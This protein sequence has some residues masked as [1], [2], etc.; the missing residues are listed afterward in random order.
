MIDFILLI[1]LAYLGWS[2][3]DKFAKLT[4]RIY[5]LGRQE[6]GGCEMSQLLKELEGEQCKF[7]FD[8]IVNY[9]YLYSVLE[10]DEEWVKLRH[11]DKKG[12][13]IVKIVRIDTIKEIEIVEQ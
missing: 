3:N 5:K 2:I 9:D 6:N 1:T 11:T 8:D 10:V 12:N 7:Q 4:K 13:S